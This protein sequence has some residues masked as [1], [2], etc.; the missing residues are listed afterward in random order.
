MAE[1]EDEK[2]QFSED[3]AKSIYDIL[4][5]SSEEEDESSSTQKR[6]SNVVDPIIC[7]TKI[8][9]H[10][11]DDGG[12]ITQI[13]NKDNKSLY[14]NQEHYSLFS[15]DGSSQDDGVRSSTCW[16]PHTEAD[17][18]QHA[19]INI[20]YLGSDSNAVF[21]DNQEEDFPKDRN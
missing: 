5:T 1:N 21:S 16:A 13:I 19:I 15:H 8:G 17:S 18:N 2:T 11:S 10:S 3:Y 6:L 14:S 12:R 7:D 4:N 9:D 20:D